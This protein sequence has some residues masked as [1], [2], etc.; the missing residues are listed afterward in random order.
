MSLDDREA[1]H[2]LAGPVY[3]EL[4]ADLPDVLERLRKQFGRIA[5]VEVAPG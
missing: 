3:R 2:R 1:L 5:P 4:D